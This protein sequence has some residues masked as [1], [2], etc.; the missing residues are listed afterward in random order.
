MANKFRDYSLRSHVMNKNIEDLSSDIGVI[1][2]SRTGRNTLCERFGRLDQG[3]ITEKLKRC[4]CRYWC[5]D[6]SKIRIE[7]KIG[8][9]L[10]RV[11][12]F[13]F[14]SKDRPPYY[15]DLLKKL[16]VIIFLFDLNRRKSTLAHAGRFLKSIKS[17]RVKREEIMPPYIFVGNK[18]DKRLSKNSAY[19]FHEKART[20]ALGKYEALQYFECSAKLSL[21]CFALARDIMINY[22][23][24]RES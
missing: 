15:E 8:T 17:D 23:P 22:I 6:H 19:V 5:I 14:K 7:G 10:L 3:R 13:F 16:N 12:L 20:K 2:G 24:P 1:G 18:K 11:H 21:G 9:T 4:H